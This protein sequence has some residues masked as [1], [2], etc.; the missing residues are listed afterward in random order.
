MQIGLSIILADL[1]ISIYVHLR[2]SGP[3][4]TV[5]EMVRFMGERE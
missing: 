4:G 3:N 1:R 5:F 2:A